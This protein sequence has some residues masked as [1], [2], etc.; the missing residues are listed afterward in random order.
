MGGGFAHFFFGKKIILSNKIEKIRDIVKPVVDSFGLI[1]DD[2]EYITHGKRWILR[3]Y[4]DKEGGVTLN[5]CEKVS[6]QISN[7]LD[8]EDIITHAY[9]L[10]V[11]SPGLDR[12]IKRIDD[13]IKYR[14]RLIK[15]N[16]LRPYNNSTA[17]R[18]RIMSAEEDKIKIETEKGGIV[19]ILFADI[20]NARLEVEFQGTQTKFES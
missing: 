12:P 7:M 8:A 9:L 18:G 15:L 20:K 16:T 19:G 6:T 10:E 4:I 13:Y 5:D 3:V 17:F 11:S 14:G 2:I 1:L